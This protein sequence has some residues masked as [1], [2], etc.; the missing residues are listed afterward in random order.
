MTSKK[1]KTQNPPYTPS[2]DT[3][4]IPTEDYVGGSRA[5]YIKG[6]E[7]ED[8]DGFKVEPAEPLGARAA[9]KDDNLSL[10]S[11]L[12]AGGVS[13][14]PADK[15]VLIRVTE[16]DRGRWGEAARLEGVS[17]SEFVRSLVNERVRGLLECSHS[18][19]KFYRWPNRPVYSICQLCGRRL[20]E[21]E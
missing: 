12:R 6:V 11:H 20:G 19:R 4:Q 21:G 8:L 17:V 2:I 5:P 18:S 7:G 16:F 14:E 15:Q 1:R 3:A 13:G 9:V 10:E